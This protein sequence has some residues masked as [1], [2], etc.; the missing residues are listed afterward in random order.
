MPRRLA[1]ALGD[2]LQGAKMD[3]LVLALRVE[4]TA[5]LE[6]AVRDW[7]PAQTAEVCGLGVAEI[8]ACA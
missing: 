1:A 2:R 4:P 8:E 6:A 7:T 5:P 3:G